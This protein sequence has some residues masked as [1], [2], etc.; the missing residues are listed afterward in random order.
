[1]RLSSHKNKNT[2]KEY[3]TKC[4]G[5]KQKEMFDSLNNTLIPKKFKPASSTVSK[6]VNT[7]TKLTDSQEKQTNDSQDIDH[8]ALNLPN[9]DLEPIEYHR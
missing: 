1:M 8:V 2:I 5:N 4:P 9:F 3:V 7:D 6:P